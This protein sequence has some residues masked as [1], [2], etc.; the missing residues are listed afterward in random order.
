[1]GNPNS[2]VYFPVLQR[3]RARLHR[4]LAASRRGQGNSM[5]RKS[6]A[7]VIAQI[8]T[9]TGAWEEFAPHTAF[10]GLTLREFKEKARPS[11]SAR[12]EI[13]N[14]QRRLAHAT[15]RRNAADA[16]TM[17]LVQGIVAGVI[18]NP[19]HG[20]D[21]VLYEAMGYV[22]KSARRKGRRRKK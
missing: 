7:D 14:L 3:I 17:R 9:V 19:D 1:M 2:P 15:R 8:K 5:A 6:P 16:R 12:T 13:E 10:Y 20:Q 22:R 11:H 4:F 21:S 18:G